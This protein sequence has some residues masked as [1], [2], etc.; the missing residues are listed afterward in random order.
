VRPVT[1]ARWPR[2]IADVP[3]SSR[4]RATWPVVKRMGLPST[5]W[6]VRR[7]C[8]FGKVRPNT[9][10]VTDPGRGSRTARTPTRASLIAKYDVF[11]Q[12]YELFTFDAILIRIR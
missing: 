1:R 2:G 4:C 3:S 5:M 10:L 9:S 6:L 8:G 11:Y 7:A 12:M